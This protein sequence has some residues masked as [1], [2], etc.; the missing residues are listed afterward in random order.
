M[1]SKYC[2]SNMWCYRCIA[3]FMYLYKRCKKL[4]KHARVMSLDGMR[5]ENVTCVYT[6]ECIQIMIHHQYSHLLNSLWCWYSISCVKWQL[7]L[8]DP[9]LQIQPPSHLSPSTLEKT[10][11]QS[12]KVTL[13]PWN[14]RWPAIQSHPSYCIMEVLRYQGQTTLRQMIMEWHT[15]H[16]DKGG[17]TLVQLTIP[18]DLVDRGEK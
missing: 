1:F 14:A 18:L 9:V 16:V 15:Q 13:W 2:V 12:M 3:I 7:T 6:N 8:N 4:I 10:E 5:Q 17:T 11:W